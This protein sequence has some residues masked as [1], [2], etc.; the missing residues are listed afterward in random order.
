MPE[1]TA[2]AA[3]R[4]AGSFSTPASTAAGP[5]RYPPLPETLRG[6]GPLKA[7]RWFGPG[8]IIASVTI[9]SGETLFASTAGAVFGYALLW[10]VM[11][12]VLCKLVQ[13][14]TGGRFMV[15]SGRHPMEAWALLPGPR[16]WF[17]ASLGALSVFCFPFWLGGLAK[18]LGTAINWMVGLDDAPEHQQELYARIIATVTLCLAVTLALVQTYR[19]LERVQTIIVG[20]LLA[21][22]LSA[23]AVAPID[24][25]AALRGTFAISIPE[26]TEWMVREYP[27]VVNKRSVLLMMAIF[28]GAIGGGTYDYIGYLGF[29]R[30]KNWGLLSH[31]QISASGTAPAIELSE[32]NLAEG[33][34][35]LRAPMTDVF[36]GF[37]CVLLFTLAFTLLGAAILH[38][39]HL[40]PDKFKLLTPQATFLTS[41]FGPSFKYVYQAGIFMAFWGTIY[42]TLEVYARTTQEC[43]QPLSRTL[44]AIP[45]RKLRTG[46]CLY[47]GIGAITLVWTVADPIHIVEPAALI[48]T[49]TCGIWCLAM[50]WADRRQL[51]EKLRMN[52]IWVV[53]NVVAGLVMISFG[54]MA[55]R[56]YLTG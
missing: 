43:F 25:M 17:P 51:P 37:A 47:A 13:V 2:P 16:G 3:P 40:V 19:I 23:A 33:R 55:I 52:R 8:A 24:W 22:I 50:I 11:A 49:T 54:A 20:L 32:A 9:G 6:G 36:I 4:E 31:N 53:L 28:M 27:D 10:F 42:G 34:K 45:Y 44:R 5:L 35:W 15:L 21:C 56:D 1:N 7:L 14:Y 41:Q 46:V 18:M 39:Q 48:G 29:F 30:E 38:P 26:H 12:A